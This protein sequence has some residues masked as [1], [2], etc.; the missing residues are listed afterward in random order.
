MYDRVGSQDTVKRVDLVQKNSRSHVPPAF[1]HKGGKNVFRAGLWGANPQ[2][3]DHD[4]EPNAMTVKRDCF[5]RWEDR[6]RPR[7]YKD[8]GDDEREHQQG[9]LPTGK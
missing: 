2:R 3:G 1:V 6:C 7:I 9:V 4:N 8:D 5:Q